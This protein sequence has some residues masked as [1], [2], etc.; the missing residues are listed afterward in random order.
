[1]KFMVILHYGCLKLKMPSPR[2]VIVVATSTTEVYRC[3][4]EG[5]TLTVA[6]ITATDFA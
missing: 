4:Q 6:N 2:G 3:E 5:T 1:M